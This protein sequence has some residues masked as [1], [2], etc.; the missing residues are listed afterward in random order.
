[1]ATIPAST[2][3]IYQYLIENNFTFSEIKIK[4]KNGVNEMVE[5]GSC[6]N[7]EITAEW[8][9]FPNP[10]IDKYTINYNGINGLRNTEITICN[11]QGA[12]VWN[13]FMQI[14][15]GHIEMSLSGF[16]F[17]IY[18]LRIRTGDRVEVFKL[19]KL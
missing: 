10:I 19:I 13:K 16:P 2:N 9:V 6:G 5:L 11:A 17:G 15:N 4:G 8:E 7:N 12:I 3:R 14:V 1:L 18:T